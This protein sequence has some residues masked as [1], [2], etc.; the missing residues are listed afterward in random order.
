MKNIVLC[1]DGTGNT[2]VKG[3]GTNVFKL[4]EAVDLNGH[5]H[6]PSLPQQIAYYDDGVGTEQNKLLKLIGGAF[7]WGL[8]RNVK[9]LYATLCRCYDRGDQIYLFGFS[10]G[11]YT[12]RTVG[13]M[14]ARY[15]ILDRS[16]FSG[17]D[18]DKKLEKAVDRI[19]KE[20]RK[21]FRRFQWVRR[22]AEQW[23]GGRRE[24]AAAD[25]DADE[26]SKPEGGEP[27]EPAYEGPIRFIGVWDTVAAVGFPF[28]EIANFV[29]EVIYP[30]RFDDLKL[31]KKKVARACHALAIDDERKTF[32]PE[33]WDESDESG[34][35]IEQ[36]WFAGVH[37]NVGGGYPKQGMSLVTLDWMMSKAADNGLRFLP[38]LRKQYQER[39]N[40]HDKL[41]NSRS[42]LKVYYR[43][44]P[45]DI[46]DLCEH[47]GVRPKI[48]VSVMHRIA[49][50][51]DGYAPGN[52]PDSFEIVSSN[53]EV[54]REDPKTLD[55]LSRQVRWQA[56]ANARRLLDAASLLV[57]MR[58]KV[59]ASFVVLS[60]GVLGLTFVPVPILS[61]TVP[62]L[63]D[64]LAGV[65][66]KLFAMVPVVGSRLS[67]LIAEWPPAVAA[68]VLILLFYAFSLIARRQMRSV[69]ARF[70][71]ERLPRPW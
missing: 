24:A 61:D 56:R 34:G 28:K 49:L 41:Y 60:L 21:T 50:A 35:R 63:P 11:A 20:F 16:V 22:T 57:G 71:R 17:G 40:V 46:Q 25:P 18:S 36:V 59:H 13:G 42:G 32:H 37:T 52:L 7:G 66:A 19:Y 15:G 23:K 39:S 68:L 38:D 70:W 47:H 29:N 6:N 67:E 30:F 2:A 27:P 64:W 51:T 26:G 12:I 62:V 14:I 3:R 1:S 45:R 4:F 54:P 55:S 44:Q 48:D 31:S 69:F 58:R 43:Y 53:P 10:R 9:Q 33:L 8:E 5:K 65:L